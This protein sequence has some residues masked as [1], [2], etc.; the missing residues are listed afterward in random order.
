[1]QAARALEGRLHEALAGR[2]TG[3]YARSRATA[4][5]ATLELERGLWGRRIVDVALMEQLV[6]DKSEAVLG[7]FAAR[8]ADPALRAEARRRVIRLRI[9]AS[10]F[11]ELRDDAAHV[12]AM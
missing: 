9:A 3:P 8:L 11:S 2:G 1:A 12:E 10:P 6:A 4:M 5:L 7:W